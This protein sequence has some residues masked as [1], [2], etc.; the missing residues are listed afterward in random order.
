M[1]RNEFKKKDKRGNL[2]PTKLDAI[3]E[4]WDNVDVELLEKIKVARSKLTEIKKDEK[5]DK[6]I[7]AKVTPTFKTKWQDKLKEYSLDE[8]TVITKLANIIVNDDDLYMGLLS[9]NVELK[10]TVKELIKELKK[11]A[12]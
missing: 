2:I 7:I 4:H 12:K 8:S 10:Q 1:K 9:E 6:T 5:K 11:Q 3:V